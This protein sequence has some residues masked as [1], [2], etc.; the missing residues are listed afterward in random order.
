MDKKFIIRQNSVYGKT[1]YEA[2]Y[3]N[4]SHSEVAKLFS[5][6]D[7]GNFLQFTSLLKESGYKYIENHDEY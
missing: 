5:C 3:Y 4:E 7:Y 1:W 2:H 6:T